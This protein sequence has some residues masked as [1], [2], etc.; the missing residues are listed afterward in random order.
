MF[1]GGGFAGGERSSRLR[2][3]FQV[4]ASGALR[5]P[6]QRRPGGGGG[7]RRVPGGGDGRPVA[8]AGAGGDRPAAQALPAVAG[9]AGPGRPGRPRPAGPG[10]VLGGSGTSSGWCSGSPRSGRSTRPAGARRGPRRTPADSRP[11]CWPTSPRGTPSPSLHRTRAAAPV[12]VVALTQHPYDPAGF[13]V[14][15]KRAG[16]RGKVKLASVYVERARSPKS[17][18]SSAASGRTTRAPSEPSTSGRPWPSSATWPRPWPGTDI[19][20]TRNT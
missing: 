6:P 12:K 10:A 20:S 11:G 3:V 4:R 13:R 1:G 18:G 15:V 7:V 9:P 2:V 16:P 8:R 17:A 14:F 5:P 19:C